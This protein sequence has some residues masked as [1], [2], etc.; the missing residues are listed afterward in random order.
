[1]KIVITGPES[2]GKSRLTKALAEH[3]NSPFVAEY[4]RQF[5]EQSGGQYTKDD[6]VTIAKGQIALEEEVGKASTD[7][8]LCDTSLEVVR[9]WSEW[10]YKTCDR[11]ILDE[12][13]KRKPDL[14]ILLKPDIPWIP[15][16]LRENPDNREEIY[17]K[18]QE[19]LKEY[20][21]RVIEIGDYWQARLHQAIGEISSLISA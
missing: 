20:D 21:T 16:P 2:T 11:F 17:E 10:K 12:A 1:M 9:I 7:L 3:F 15:D 19:V 18:Y 8:I 5:L 14:F 6:L 4:A 13:L